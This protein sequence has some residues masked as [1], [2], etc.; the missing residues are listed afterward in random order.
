MDLL[1][2]LAMQ[3]LSSLSEVDLLA[4]MRVEEVQSTYQDRWMKA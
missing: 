3:A 4:S 1:H 2:R